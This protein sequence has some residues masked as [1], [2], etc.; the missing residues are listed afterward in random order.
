MP[1]HD[2]GTPS[3]LAAVVLSVYAAQ[4]SRSQ[5][6]RMKR[7]ALWMFAKAK[8]SSL[9]SRRDSGL[10]T[11]TLLYILLGI[12]VLILAFIAPVLAIIL[13]LAGVIYLLATNG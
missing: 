2:S 10:S 3:L 9:F 1:A 4:L 12:L 7:K 5:M 8:V 6:R 11:R 13:L